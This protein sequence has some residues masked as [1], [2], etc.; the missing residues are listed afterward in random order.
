MNKV[1]ELLTSDSESP[2]LR[3]L[4]ESNSRQAE[5]IGQLVQAI[6]NMAQGLCM[7]DGDQ[8]IIVCN[9]KYASM[10]GLDPET[11]RP[12]TLRR[13]MIERLVAGGIRFAG[14]TPESY[15]RERTE[16]VE[17]VVDKIHRLADGRII[18]VSRRPLSGGGWVATHQDITELKQR[19]A[20]FQL[21]F[22]NNPVPMWVCDRAT[23]RC[24]AVN[25]AAIDHYGHPRESFLELRLTDLRAVQADGDAEVPSFGTEAERLEH[26]RKSDG[27]L[28]D[29][30]IYA[31]ELVYDGVDAVL[32][33]MIDI[34]DRRLAERRIAHLAH[35]DMLTGLFNRAA[36]TERLD[37]L[38]RQGDKPF[39]LLLVDLDH[40]KE[41]NDIFGH[42]VG[43][44]FL[45]AVAERLRGPAAG[46]FLARIGGDE[47]V[48]IAE[49]SQP[50]TALQLAER[51]L[52]ISSETLSLQGHEVDIGLSIG[53]AL[54]PDNGADAVTLIAN[55][56]AVL[57]RVKGE[58][59]GSARLFEPDMDHKIHERHALVRELRHAVERD[60]L[61]LHYQP[62]IA[63]DGRIAGFE[64]L[65]RWLHPR[66][67][68]LSPGR[69]IALAEETGLIG[70]LG[71]WVLREACREAA[72]WRKPLTVAVNLSPL[73]FRQ[74]D[75]F[76]LIHGVLFESGLPPFRLELEI[77]ESVLMNDR[78]GAI[79]A[80][81]Q[82]KALGVQIALDDFGTGYSSLSYLQSFPFDKIKL[83]AQFVAELGSG[84]RAATLIRGVIALGH[85]LDMTMIAEG[86]ETEAQ[87][88]FLLSERIDQLQ[89]YLIGRPMPIENYAAIIGLAAAACGMPERT[90]MA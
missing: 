77:T 66:H 16:G 22:D 56:D 62:Q 69:F 9:D 68:L 65:V 34:T 76:Q 51:L 43:D 52:A 55:A 42:V 31:R 72:T 85:G 57:Y 71:E 67:G 5:Q 1:T 29:V 80:L 21:L 24:L 53:I 26:H 45:S 4:R 87:R 20:S 41:V 49:G 47:F 50:D 46:Y 82:I 38:L 23:L 30:S 2:E 35:H 10:Y 32:M 3:R 63:A 75:L 14:E 89:G 27:S 15:L 8:R 61:V 79:S 70:D 36:F 33:S 17:R 58:G 54:Y 83:D 59:R 18:A 28:I 48:I 13:D 40:F 37:D 84:P 7:F 86:V 19:E 73:Q 88:S 6:N 44:A 39:A 60:E 74:K 64:A 12:G 11:V 25:Q 90:V 81:R 78:M